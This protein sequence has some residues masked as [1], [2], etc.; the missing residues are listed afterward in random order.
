L[1]SALSTLF[2]FESNL[3]NLTGKKDWIVSAGLI[4]EL[5][6]C[7][8]QPIVVV[9]NRIEFY[10][11]YIDGS[12]NIDLIPIGTHAMAVRP[13]GAGIDERVELRDG[14]AAQARELTR[15]S[16]CGVKAWYVPTAVVSEQDAIELGEQIL[17]AG[18]FRLERVGNAMLFR[19]LVGS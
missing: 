15:S 3:L 17:G 5:E 14:E 4:N 8:A 7:V 16:N 10:R 2:E 1:L 18:N 6:E 12:K 11:H 13:G 9:A 19:G